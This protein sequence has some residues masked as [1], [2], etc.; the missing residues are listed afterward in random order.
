MNDLKKLKGLVNYLIPLFLIYFSIFHY[1]YFGIFI[2]FI[3]FIKNYLKIE[4]MNLIF[5]KYYPLFFYLLK[6]IFNLDENFNYFHKSSI[7]LNY[8]EKARFLDLQNLFL[9]LVCNSGTGFT[10]TFNF[11]HNYILSCPY[12]NYWGPLSTILSLNNVDVWISTL[13]LSSIALIVLAWLY[14]SEYKKLD[15]NHFLLFALSIS[16]PVNFLIDRMNVDIFIFLI[17]FILL[18]NIKKNLIFKLIILSV[19]TLYKLHPIILFFSIFIYFCLRRHKIE[20]LITLIFLGVNS[21]IIFNFYSQNNFVTA[22]PYLSYRSFGVLSDATFISKF[23]GSIVTSYLILILFLIILTYFIYKSLKQNEYEL[24]SV[25]FNIA[26]W[27]IGVSMYSNYDYRIPILIFIFLHLFKLDIYLLNISLLIFVFLSP[28][29][30]S[31]SFIYLLESNI[32][33]NNFIDVSFYIILG[34]L[35]SIQYLTIKSVRKL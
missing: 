12:K 32:F 29:P 11:D 3:F 9:E 10:H 19:F 5:Y 31:N 4:I 8:Y 35:I 14:L 27:F 34:Y 1:K 6:F 24:N 2:L 16:P 26:S 7:Q 20:S 18:K 15:T 17:T 30:I 22:R 13:L 21:I 33:S 23:L 25:F 28:F